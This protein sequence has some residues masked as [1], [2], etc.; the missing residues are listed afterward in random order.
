MLRGV[1]APSRAALVAGVAGVLLGAM[2]CR[3]DPPDEPAAPGCDDL[4]RAAEATDL[5]G[6]V[7]A[8]LD[9]DATAPIA[10]VQCVWEG[11]EPPE[12]GGLVATAHQLQ[13]Q[14]HE[15]R[16]FYEPSAWS[17]QPE[18]IGDLG[19]EAFTVADSIGGGPVAAYR[20]GDLVVFLTYAVV[21]GDLD[22]QSKQ[23]LVAFLVCL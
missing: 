1:V 3:D 7:D 16:G 19:E 22:A 4:V 10:G 21:T 23:D 18:P 15:G 6:G 17:D 8:N 20:D 13:L 5:F 14:V 12:P 9:T 11:I 2:A